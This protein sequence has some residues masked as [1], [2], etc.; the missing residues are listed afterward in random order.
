MAS[1]DTAILEEETFYERIK[2]LRDE[3]GLTQEKLASQMNCSLST[4]KRLENGQ[5]CGSPNEYLNLA[6]VLGV[7]IDELFGNSSWIDRFRNQPHDYIIKGI[8]ALLELM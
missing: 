1:I 6:S 5:F 3:N 8:N 7:S 2:R 4:I